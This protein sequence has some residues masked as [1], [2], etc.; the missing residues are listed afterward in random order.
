MKWIF[1]LAV[2]VAFS[3]CLH[4]RKRIPERQSSG[5]K[6]DSSL[7]QLPVHIQP[8]TGKLSL[9]ADFQHT[10]NGFVTLYLIN[11]TNG[12][13]AV[14]KQDG[15]LYCKREAKTADGT[16]RRCDSHQSSWCGNSYGSRDLPAG[17][18][19]SW[20]QMLNSEHGK[21]R[22]VRFRLFSKLDV[23]SNEGSGK[24]TDADIHFC[25]FDAMAMSSAPF[26]DVAA[27]ATGDVQGSQGSSLGDNM[28]IPALARFAEDPRMF[29]VLKRAVKRLV[30]Q[31]R[32][33]IESFDY[34]QCLEVLDKAKDVSV[35]SQECWD[36]V[37]G[38]VNDPHFP[39]SDSALRWLVS[40]YPQNKAALRTMMEGVL[41]KP[42][43]PAMSVAMYDYVDVAG[44]E[45]ALQKLDT[46]AE[47]VVYSSEDRET[48]RDVK[49]SLL[50]KREK[51]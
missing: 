6:N 47:G 46:I 51:E 31:K 16:W 39:W 49:K 33:Q 21:L 48:A 27:V 10:N 13:I 26:E 7:K 41:T 36:Y 30:K 24:I 20:Q 19:L 23:K 45:A 32:T 22:P 25:R 4:A 43:H 11:A 34:D 15:D 28:A 3:S 29:P 12:A 44:R 35:S 50:S 5:L 17:G 1:V 38:F 37:A 9:T 2:T 8:V 18:F 40:H 14:P 42:G